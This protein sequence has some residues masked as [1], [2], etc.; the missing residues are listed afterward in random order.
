MKS[1]RILRHSIQQVT[2]N[3]RAALML[4]LPLVIL[5]AASQM[6]LPTTAATEEQGLAPGAAAVLLLV[7]ILGAA[8]SL[9]LAVNW[10]RHVL[11]AEHATLRPRGGRMGVYLLRGVQIWFLIMVAALVVF[12]AVTALNAVLGMSLA[13]FTDPEGPSLTVMLIAALGAVMGVVVGFWIYAMMMRLSVMLPAAAIGKGFGPRQA[14]ARTRGTSGTMV[15]LLILMG[16]LL[17][18]LSLPVILAH[19]A[20]LFVF[21]N[22]LGFAMNWFLTLLGISVLTTLYGHYVEGRALN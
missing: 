5:L 21:A 7:M 22:V 1:Y 10:H 6:M 18:V 13:L 2:G 12:L 16:V 15:M 4:S 8:A 11:L 17:V 9:L 19:V 3:P 20:E 14:L